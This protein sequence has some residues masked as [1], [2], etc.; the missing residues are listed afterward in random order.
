[1]AIS[2]SDDETF[3]TRKFFFNKDSGL[4]DS[5]WNT[6]FWEKVGPLLEYWAPYDDSTAFA[7]S[8]SNKKQELIETLS[9]FGFTGFRDTPGL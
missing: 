2:N 3:E 1:M 5:L 8:R 4:Y 7:I 9:G 6:N